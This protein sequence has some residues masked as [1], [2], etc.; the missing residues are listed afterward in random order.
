MRFFKEAAKKETSAAGDYCTALP[1]PGLSRMVNMIRI[2]LRITN[3]KSKSRSHSLYNRG[4]GSTKRYATLRPFRALDMKR[5]LPLAI[6]AATLFVAGLDAVEVN[7]K[8][9]FVTKRG[10][11]PVVEET[12]IWLEPLAARHA[13]RRTPAAFQITTRGK[14]LVPH[15]LA[16]PAGSSI[17]FPNEDPISH[18]LFS[19]SASNAFDLGLYRKGPGKTQ[20][21]EAPGVVNIYCNVHPNMSAVLHV[22]P[23]PYYAW[24]DA[25]GNY[26]VDVPP[27]KYRLVAWNEQGGQSE[28]TV[29]VT[30]TGVAGNVAL[31][32]DSRNAR[33]KQHLNKEGKPYQSPARREY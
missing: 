23:T 21:F 7:G 27:G 20:K 4:A 32:I 18:N 26:S 24:A 11:R 30:S 1:P 12:L 2:L 3:S 28:S 15:V 16:V 33:L 8:V 13:A 25:A 6:C 22:M 17:S 9:N 10:Q 29:D 19:L 14:M 31:T 5:L